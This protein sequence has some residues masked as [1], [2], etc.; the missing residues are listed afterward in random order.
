[1]AN[2]PKR[3]DIGMLSL[4]V[5]GILAAFFT[6]LTMNHV[7]INW[8]W[9]AFAYAVFIVGIIRTFVAHGVPHWP[10][11]TKITGSLVIIVVFGLLALFGVHQQ[12]HLPALT[13]T[14]C[15]N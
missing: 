9:S 10:K 15:A 1:M 4:F 12:Y 3:P 6:L 11:R 14:A 7:E 8:M 5:G 2:L 13:T